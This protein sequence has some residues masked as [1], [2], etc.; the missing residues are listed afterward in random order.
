MATS[1][2][3]LRLPPLEKLTTPKNDT[4]TIHDFKVKINFDVPEDGEVYPRS[5]FATLLSIIIQQ[6][7]ATTLEP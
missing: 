4:A 1:T 7:L 3:T 5:K 2:T 6:F